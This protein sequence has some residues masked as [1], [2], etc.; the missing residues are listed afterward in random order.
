MTTPEK[1]S[2]T[3]ETAPAK[4]TFD[5]LHEGLSDNCKCTEQENTDDKFSGHLVRRVRDLKPL[6][7]D[8]MSKHEEKKPYSGNCCK[9]E[10]SYR[11]VSVFSV[12]GENEE[13]VKRELKDNLK[14][15]PRLPRVYCKFKLKDGA[16]M[17]WPTP[18]D[19]GIYIYHC[20]LLKSDKFS[21]EHIEITEVCSLA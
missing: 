2:E 10:C 8:F 11:G 17:I 15:K 3:A 1:N 20:D 14:N 6:D 7:T 9:D 16:G 21:L 13:T 4:M 12:N 5:K 19:Q 18:K